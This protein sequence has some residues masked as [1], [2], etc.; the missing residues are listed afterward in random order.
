MRALKAGIILAG[1]IAA[2]AT[3]Q[4]AFAQAA[5]SEPSAA[6]MPQ[7]LGPGEI[8]VTDNNRHRYGELQLVPPCLIACSRDLD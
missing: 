6:P 1:M 3:Q 2:C 8:N 7:P 5:P 4:Q